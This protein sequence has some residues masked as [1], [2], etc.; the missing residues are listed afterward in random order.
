MIKED[1]ENQNTCMWL[2]HA[3]TIIWP[4]FLYLRLDCMKA[5]RGSGKKLKKLRKDFSS[6]SHELELQVYFSADYLLAYSKNF[7]GSDDCWLLI[8]VSWTCAS[9]GLT[10][11]G[12]NIRAARCAAHY[13]TIKI[14]Q[15]QSNGKTLKTKHNGERLVGRSIR[16]PCDDVASGD[17]TYGGNKKQILK[18]RLVEWT[19]KLFT[20]GCK[21]LWFW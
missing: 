8:F 9:S 10:S 17:E 5:E 14:N 3:A 16:K 4:Q 12:T 20:V 2:I 18:I 21:F 13:S 15:S 7:V 19:H 11:P 6:S 1:L